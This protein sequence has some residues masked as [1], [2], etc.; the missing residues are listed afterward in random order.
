SGVI[1]IAFVSSS[2]VIFIAFVSSSGE[3]SSPTDLEGTFVRNGANPLLVPK[4]RYHWFDGDGMVHGIQ[5]GG[6]QAT[7]RNRYVRTEALVAEREAGEPLWTGILE[8]VEWDNPRGPFKNSANTDLVYHAGKLLALWWQTGIPY[9]L[10]LPELETRGPELFGRNHRAGISA[11]P[12][13][14]PTTGEMMFM[15]FGPKAPYLSYGVVDAHGELV[16]FTAIDSVPGGRYQHDIAITEHYTLLMDLPMY[17][18]PELLKLGKSRVR[19]FR[20]RPARFG[21]IPRHGIDAEVRW[22]EFDACY[23]YHT[24]NAW[25]EGDEVVMIGCRI[26]DPLVGD[27]SNPQRAYEVPAIGLQRLEPRLWEWR[28]NLRTGATHERALGDRLR[29]FPRMDNRRLGTKSRYSYLPAI[30][31]APTLLFEGLVKFDHETGLEETYR[32]PEGV[33]GG[34]AVVC[35]RTGST[36]EDDAYLLSFTTSLE[37][38]SELYVWSAREFGE[39]IAKVPL[40]QR[41]PVGYHAYWAPA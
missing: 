28:M 40:P 41:V 24:I 15:T 27:P 25:E 12:K 11:H 23:I 4:G 37:G 3:A 22:F 21:L 6:G 5:I 16:H 34:E 26:A 19:F 32:Y 38:T 2:G 9:E 18:D 35:P 17:A 7:Y 31:P 14:D 30:A 13:V 1:F 36:G 8:P 20:D 29:E 33:F 39:P 10:S